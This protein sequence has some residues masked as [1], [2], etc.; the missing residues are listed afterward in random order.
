MIVIIWRVFCKQN[1]AIK[2]INGEFSF[3]KISL[4]YHAAIMRHRHGDFFHEKISPDM[5]FREH[6]GKSNTPFLL[7]TLL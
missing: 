5:Y 6:R 4:Q 1:L 7:K 2:I 3:D